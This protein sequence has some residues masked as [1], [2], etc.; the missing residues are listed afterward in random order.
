MR[1]VTAL[2]SNKKSVFKSSYLFL[3]ALMLLMYSPFA[4]IYS[5]AGMVGDT[6]IQ[7]KLG[8]DSISMGH[9]ITEEIYSWHPD[10]VF[11]AHESGWYLLLGFLYKTF[12]IWGIIILGIVFNYAT[13][14]TALSYNRDKAHPFV[15]SLVI[16]LTPVIGRF[17]S[18][19]I[20]PNLIS[21]FLLTLLLVSFLEEWKVITKAVVF[22][23]SCFFLG[24]LHGGMLPMF[25]VIF[26][27]LIIIEL[28][29]RNFR[30]VLILAGA[31]VAG[32]VVSLLNPIGIRCYT[33]G[34]IQSSATDVWSEIAEW[35]PMDF[36]IIQAFLILLVLAGFM[37]N[38][39]VRNFEKKAVTNLALF[40]MFLIMTCVY[41]RFDANL[42]I[43]FLLAAPEQYGSLLKWLMEVVVRTKKQ[44][45]IDFSDGFY[46]VLAIVCVVMIAVHGGISIPQYL[47]TGTFEDVERLG[48]MDP[49]AA[50][51]ILDHGYERI[52]NTFD[53]G[54]WLVF[55]GV[56][57]HIDNR[58]D[59]YLEEFSGVDHIS[60]Q[61]NCVTI[62][63]LDV[64]AAKYDCDAFLL[65]MPDGF[66]YLLYEV[67]R[68]APDRYRIVY[69]NVVES[70]IDE[71]G[72]RRF[73]IIECT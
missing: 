21:I 10:L 8:L 39:G 57:V 55:R 47:P 22:V 42:A 29:Y 38:D 30:D 63:D 50:Q 5:V 58:V 3:C 16:I 32:F 9:F 24:W 31:L 56:K 64:F 69:D 19:N 36:S 60:D 14:I 13:G 37:T 70:P 48:A 18:Y 65:D 2:K 20:R 41:N 72:S 52:F 46:R 11:T 35:L 59:P 61:M 68:Y 25:I 28:V 26:A 6:A 43:I 71:I 62:T 34:M 49:D 45:R 51:Y 7:I 15:V 73:V 33:Y 23:V 1:E 67:E 40:F 53:T 12:N 4:G 17:P 66:S 44:I 27:V 54:S